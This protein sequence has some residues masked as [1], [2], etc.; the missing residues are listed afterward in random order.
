MLGVPDSDSETWVM[1]L[2]TQGTTNYTNYGFNSF[3]LIGQ[4][5][6]G[7]GPDGIFV[8][9]GD[10][11]AGEPIRAN[12]SVGELDFGTALQKTISHA[13]VGMSAKGNLFMKVLVGEGD[14]ARAYV[15]KTRSFSQSLKQQRIVC[16]QGLKANYATIEFYNEEGADFEI[17]TVE[18]HVAD[19]KRRI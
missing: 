14:E 3:A 13:Y 5:Y 12:W 2:G 19:L 15:Y 8:L 11:D 18:F 9:D 7:A 16:G 10:T 17:D 1:N 6:Y 4:R